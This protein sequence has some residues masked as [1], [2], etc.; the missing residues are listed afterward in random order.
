VYAVEINEIKDYCNYA[1]WTVAVIVKTFGGLV[2]DWW[3]V[4]GRFSPIVRWKGPF[5]TKQEY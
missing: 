4:G 3:A 1:W 2:G 5:L